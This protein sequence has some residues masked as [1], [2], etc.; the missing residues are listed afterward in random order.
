MD[1]LPLRFFTDTGGGDWISVE[2]ARRL[3]HAVETGRVGD[4]SFD[5][6][7]MP[8]FRPDAAIP[9]YD[10]DHD[11]R[12][13]LLRGRLVVSTPKPRIQP[14]DGML[15]Q[16]WFGGRIWTFDYAH[17]RLLLHDD[18]PVHRPGAEAPLGFPRDTSGRPTAHFPSIE[19]SIE[20][21]THAFLFDTGATVRL[22]ADAHATAD[23]GPVE[24]ATSFVAAW[25]FDTWRE[26]HPDWRTVEDA[27]ANLHGEPMIEVPSVTV[28]GLEAGP[29]WFTR[30]PDTNFHDF[31]SSMM[32]RRVEGALGGS[33]LRYFSITVDYPRAV[34]SFQ[35]TA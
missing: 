12:H 18:P 23:P 34:A 6:V 31:M 1:G 3:P 22:T 32:D 2:A 14:R 16:A 13:P 29:V 20:G 8:D 24:R 30:R 15:G 35:K 33:L 28:A 25:L 21:A 10:V 17:R 26:R 19:A 27:D 9:P 4:S 11:T 7:P 5:V